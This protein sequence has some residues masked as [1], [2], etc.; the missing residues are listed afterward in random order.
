MLRV[1]FH[2]KGRNLTVVAGKL[3][4]SRHL[5]FYRDRVWMVNA[6]VNDR[7]ECPRKWNSLKNGW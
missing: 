3:D 6:R 2:R 7:L 4:I 1:R 5:T